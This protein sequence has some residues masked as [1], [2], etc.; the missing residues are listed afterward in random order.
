MPFFSVLRSLAER[1]AEEAEEERQAWAIREQAEAFRAWGRLGSSPMRFGLPSAGELNPIGIAYERDRIEDRSIRPRTW[2]RGLV[3][4]TQELQRQAEEEEEKRQREES[5]RLLDRQALAFQG[6]DPFAREREAEQRPTGRQSIGALDLLQLGG[7]PQSA[8]ALLERAAGIPLP[9]AEK[10]EQQRLQTELQQLAQE[11][12]G[13]SALREAQLGGNVIPGNIGQSP[14]INPFI[15]TEILEAGLN[16]LPLGPARGPVQRSIEFTLSPAGLVAGVAAPGALAAGEALAIGGGT[17]G[18]AAG[19]PDPVVLGLEI[20]GGVLGGTGII[21]GL[22]RRGLGRLSRATTA[23][24]ERPPTIIERP[25]SRVVEDVV[26]PVERGAAGV[27]PSGRAPEAPAP[28]VR[29]EEITAET[30]ISPG[31]S[32][33]SPLTGQQVAELPVGQL[34]RRCATLG[35]NL[36]FRSEP[37]KN[38]LAGEGIGYRLI[39]EARRTLDQ[40]AYRMLSRFEPLFHSFQDVPKNTLFSDRYAASRLCNRANKFGLWQVPYLPEI[41]P[42]DSLNRIAECLR[43]TQLTALEL[44]RFG[45]Y[46]S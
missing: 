22:G 44:L 28:P 37:T 30:V 7:D 36:A 24:P 10:Q 41:R 46:A 29:T 32:R 20:G 5:R 16:R 13:P 3:E 33:T 35:R 9:T 27:P 17:A 4:R 2:F 25:P 15:P 38:D 34:E 8:Q 21:S 14:F 31:T 11:G 45:Q 1:I 23:I 39:H 42:V 6:I 19:L 26:L 12:Q 40:L 43:N 18:T